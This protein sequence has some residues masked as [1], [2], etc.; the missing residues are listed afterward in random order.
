MQRNCK[1]KTP[2]GRVSRA[3]FQTC[4]IWLKYI[5]LIQTV[6]L[7]IHAERECIWSEHL[8]AV[9]AILNVISAAEHLKYLKAVVSYLPEMKALR[10]TPSEVA[11]EFQK[12]NFVVKSACGRFNGIWTD[13]ALECSKN[14][15]QKVRLDRLAC[16]VL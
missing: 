3:E 15:M 5:E 4:V 8:T 10:Q 9:T 7:Y 13:M 11:D 12:G 1:F 14:V 6:L 2:H 16:K